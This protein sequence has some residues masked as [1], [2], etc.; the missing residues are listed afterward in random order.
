MLVTV[1]KETRLSGASDL[2]SETSFITLSDIG[3]INNNL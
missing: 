1:T 3:N 2:S